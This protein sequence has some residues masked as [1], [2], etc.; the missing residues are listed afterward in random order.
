MEDLSCRPSAGEEP[1]R[2]ILP[3]ANRQKDNAW[4]TAESMTVIVRDDRARYRFRR[5]DCFS[6]F[7]DRP[8]RS[9]PNAQTCR[10]DAVLSRP[11]IAVEADVSSTQNS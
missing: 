5:S 3:R 8:L 6:N 4:E 10:G 7:T 2:L 1:A 11:K 9:R